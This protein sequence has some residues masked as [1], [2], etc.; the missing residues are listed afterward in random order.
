VIGRVT[1]TAHNSCLFSELG[2]CDEFI[3]QHQDPNSHV[4]REMHKW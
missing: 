1:T 2:E 3:S 4:D